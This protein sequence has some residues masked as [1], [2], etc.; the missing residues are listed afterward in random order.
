MAGFVSGGWPVEAGSAAR[1]RC[2]A[3]AA[4]RG[5]L[6][7]RGAPL[8]ARRGRARRREGPVLL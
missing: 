5:G 7:G 3:D 6:C 8:A 2:P 1:W 4:G